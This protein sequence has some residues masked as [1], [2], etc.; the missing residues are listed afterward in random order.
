[1]RLET[2]VKAGCSRPCGSWK[3][4]NV[5]DAVGSLRR[6]KAGAR[7]LSDHSW[8]GTW[9]DAW[10]LGGLAMPLHG[11]YLAWG[12][13]KSHL[14]FKHLGLWIMVDHKMNSHL[15]LWGTHWKIKSTV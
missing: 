12:C 6:V 7:E 1:M 5:L 14:S 8:S 2:E 4:W 15:G 3:A 13:G 9:V 10:P 11:A